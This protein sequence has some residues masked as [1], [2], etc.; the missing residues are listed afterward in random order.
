MKPTSKLIV[1]VATGFEQ[2]KLL[3]TINCDRCERDEGSRN[4]QYVF[5]VH[6]KKKIIELEN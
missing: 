2:L 5:V 1:Y 4:F 3:D 6:K